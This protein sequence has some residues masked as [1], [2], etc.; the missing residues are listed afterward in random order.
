[1]TH[2]RRKSQVAEGGLGSSHRRAC[3]CSGGTV[4]GVRFRYVSRGTLHDPEKLL[5]RILRG[6]EKF[7]EQYQ[8]TDQ[9]KG[10]LFVGVSGRRGKISAA[11]QKSNLPKAV[12]FASINL[13][14]I[15][16][17]LYAVNDVASPSPGEA[18]QDLPSLKKQPAGF[19]NLVEILLEGDAR[20][21]G[22]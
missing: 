22:I 21:R 3:S 10:D 13:W 18:L 17:A 16:Q 19:R 2:Y 20:A 14:P 1:M 5:P 11:L 6:A 12:F 4:P 8:A 9:L 15:N 7:R